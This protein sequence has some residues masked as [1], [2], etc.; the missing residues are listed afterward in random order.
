MIIVGCEYA[1]QCGDHAESREVGTGNQFHID[2]FR[3]AAKGKARGS[4]KAAKHVGKDFVVILKIPEHGMRDGVAAPIAAVVAPPHGEQNKL[5]RILD[6]QEPQQNLVEEGENS[7]VRANAQGQ[8]QDGYSRKAGSSRE[9]AEGVFQVSKY[10]INPAHDVH[11]AWA[12]IDGL[13]HRKP[14]GS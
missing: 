11:A 14:P 13:G 6:G 7:G 8:S 2:A 3:L 12:L 1:S 5:L 10:G 9:H 4:R